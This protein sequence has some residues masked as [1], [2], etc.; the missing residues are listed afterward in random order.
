MPKTAAN[1]EI[2]AAW[3][4]IEPPRAA[5][6]PQT[7]ERH[8][9][10]RTDPYAWLRDAGYP[11]VEDPEILAY[12]NAENAYREAVLAPYGKLGDA[13]FEEIKARIKEDDTD[14]PYPHGPFLYQWREEAG[15]QYSVLTRK[16]RDAPPEAPFDTLI[17]ENTLAEGLDYFVLAAVAP[18][19]DHALVAYAVDTKGDEKYEIRF[20]D[21]NGQDLDERIEGGSGDIVWAAD[22]QHLFYLVRDEHH[23]P[24]KLYRHRLGSDPAEDPLILEETDPG[25]V[26]WIGKSRDGRTLFCGAHETE[27]T[28]VRFLA[29]DDPLGEWTLIEPRRHGHRYMPDSHGR[30]LFILTNDVSRTYRLVTADMDAPS[31]IAWRERIAAREDVTLNDIELFRDHMVVRERAGGLPR[32]VVHRLRDGAQH[33]IDMPE[34]AYALGSGTNREF[35]TDTFRFTYTSLK[36]PP[37]TLDYGVESR[38]RKILKE[39]EIPSGYDADAYVAER[40]MIPSQDGVEVPV[41]LIRHKDTPVDGSAPLYLY[42]YGSYGHAMP[43][44]FSPHRLSLLDRG[45]IYAIAH[46]RGGS[47][48]GEQW[49]DAGKLAHKMN[50]F[51]DV[52]AAGRGLV[53]R[54]YT[55]AGRLTVSGGSAGGLMV[56]AVINLDSELFHAAV[57][58]VPFV[59]TLNTMLDDS[60]PLTPGEFNEWGNPIVDREAYFRIKSYSPYDNLEAKRYP[61]L[62]V[63]GGIADPRVTYWEPAKWTAALRAIKR[64][65]GTDDNLILM[66]MNM[67]AGH[68]GAS[69]RFDALRELAEQYL[70]LLLV[71]GMIGDE[72]G[73][74]P[75]SD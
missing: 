30:T 62:Y 42:A 63:T 71:H 44:S 59:D 6:R 53:A 10:V 74:P 54:G 49:Y 65:H 64:E 43:V 25:F 58:S 28:E 35:D 19:P 4:G 15:K 3:R 34:P 2:N 56:G 20:R 72:P 12:L 68:F 69:G 24:N 8:G 33:V 22:G 67:G 75:T 27:A 41:S 73:A 16:R 21:G 52:V 11:T 38:A 40:L 50:T 7:I 51:F 17:D 61:H 66:R 9:D 29:A 55:S 31:A 26:L 5:A 37:Q 46:P 36:T 32:F 23:R 14:P 57:A 13:L 70:F 1:S 60:L 48:M 45:F 47:E 18:T 39:M